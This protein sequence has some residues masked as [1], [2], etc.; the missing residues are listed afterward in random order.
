MMQ[1]RQRSEP[2]VMIPQQLQN[3][4][5]MVW[6]TYNPPAMYVFVRRFGGFPISHDAWEKQKDALE[7]DLLHDKHKFHQ[8][9]YFTVG[10][11]SPW[12]LT[13]RRNEVWLK[14]LDADHQFPAP[15]VEKEYFKDGLHDN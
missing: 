4:W 11:D 8:G 13:K 14:C 15:G 6:Y 10:Y 1:L 12:K 7:A 3:P 2:V 5:I 9:E